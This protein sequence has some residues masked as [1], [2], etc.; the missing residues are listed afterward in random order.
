MSFRLATWMIWIR[1]NGRSVNEESKFNVISKVFFEASKERY[2]YISHL[3]TS[4]SYFLCFLF[5]L[6]FY[7]FLT[8]YPA[9]NSSAGPRRLIYNFRR[10]HRGATVL[11]LLRDEAQTVTVINL[12]NINTFARSDRQQYLSPH[13]FILWKA[14]FTLILCNNVMTHY[15]QMTDP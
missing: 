9:D 1:E 12:R 5:D 15:R 7:Y 14:Y 10:E 6:G 11:E 3:K 4:A 2:T 8:T 13:R